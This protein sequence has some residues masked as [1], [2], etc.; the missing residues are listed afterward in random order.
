MECWGNVQ[1]EENFTLSG[2]DRAVYETQWLN[3]YSY[4]LSGERG[5]SVLVFCDMHHLRRQQLE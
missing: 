2:A 3:S 5:L 4:K 1:I